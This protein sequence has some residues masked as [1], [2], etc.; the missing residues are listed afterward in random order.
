MIERVKEEIHD[1]RQAMQDQQEVVIKAW[2]RLQR[3]TAEENTAK[4]NAVDRRADGGITDK[5][6]EDIRMARKLSENATVA[7]RRAEHRAFAEADQYRLA[8]QDYQNKEEKLKTVRTA[9]AIFEEDLPGLV[10][11]ANKIVDSSEDEMEEE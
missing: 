5:D 6:L 2:Q 11:E 3:K 10:D 9:F 1:S 4:V 7:M 8:K